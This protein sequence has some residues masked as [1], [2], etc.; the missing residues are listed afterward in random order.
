MRTFQHTK[1]N[2]KTGGRLSPRHPSSKRRGQALVE[3]ALVATI[4][5][6]LSMGLIQYGIIYTTTIQLTNLARDG[7]RFA[8]IHG[9]ESTVETQVEDYIQTRT[10]NGTT[11][12]AA[13]VPDANI[14]VVRP[15]GGSSGQPVTVT[16][17]YDMRR[18]F[19]LPVARWAGLN[20]S[21]WNAYGS[22]ATMIIE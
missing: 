19:I 1:A 4:L 21:F 22:S 15:N 9:T 20:Q 18:K 17:T 10:V 13:D 3:M 12:R 11:I 16:V 6:F 7:A 2:L 8:A 14:A 5:I